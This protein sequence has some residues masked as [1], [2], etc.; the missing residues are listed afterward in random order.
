MDAMRP[1]GPK[2]K[3]QSPRSSPKPYPHPTPQERSGYLP[4]YAGVLILSCGQVEVEEGTTLRLTQCSL[5][6]QVQPGRSV[7][8][9]A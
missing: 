6:D 3:S 4:H 8:K 5:G 9:V 1:A 2:H 7:L